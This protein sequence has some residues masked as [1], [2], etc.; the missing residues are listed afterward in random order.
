MA[1]KSKKSENANFLVIQ[2]N[3]ENKWE[4]MGGQKWDCKNYG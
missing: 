3:L 2:I 4:E 1:K